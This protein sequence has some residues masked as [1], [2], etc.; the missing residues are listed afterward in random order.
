MYKLPVMMEPEGLLKLNLKSIYFYEKVLNAGLRLFLL[1]LFEIYNSLKS[2]LAL[3]KVILQSLFVIVSMVTITGCNFNSTQFENSELVKTDSVAI[4]LSQYKLENSDL[5]KRKEYLLKAY[6]F[7]TKQPNDTLKNRN[8]LKITYEAYN[9]NDT[10]F[11]KKLN[12]EAQKL[13][14]KIRDTFGIADTHWNYG[15][16]LTDIEVMDSAYYH[17]HQAYKNFLFIKKDYHSGIMLYNMA[18]I[19]GRLRD[20]TGSEISLFQAITKFKKLKKYR[21]LYQ[22]YNYLG[23]IYTEMEEFDSAIYYHNK[24]LEY[25]RQ[26]ENKDDH[27]GGSLNNI[28]L[29]YQ[30]QGNHTK[31]IDFFNTAL[32]INLKNKNIELYARLIDNIAYSKFKNADTINIKASFL[33]ALHLRDSIKNKSGVVISKIHLAEYFATQADTAT[34]LTYA[35]QAYQLSSQIIN[36]RD[37]LSILLLLSKLDKNKSENHLN[38]YIILSNKLEF[39]DRKIRNKFAKIRFETDEYITETEKLSEQKKLIIGGSITGLLFF[40]LL[41]FI[42]IQRSKNKALILESEQQK[43]NEEIYSLLLKQQSKL[44]E[45]RLKERQRIAEE[46]HDGVLSKIFGTRLGLGFLSIQGDNETLEKHT[47]F[48]EELQLIEKEIRAISHELKTEFLSANLDY[49]LIIEDLLKNKS[50]I[51]KFEYTIEYNN[52]PEWEAIDDIIKIHFYRILQEALQNIIKYATA[53]KVVLTFNSE[54]GSLYFSISDNGTGFDPKTKHK[55]IGLKNMQS[56][57]KKLQGKLTIDTAINKGTTI[58]VSCPIIT[59]Y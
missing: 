58:F 48:I 41:F 9:L 2:T 11:F 8:L 25:L 51:G 7:N 24:A 52:P 30:K 6:Y 17:Y 44:E 3:Y 32:N 55:G 18:F 14:V 34:A 50:T 27:E 40:S 22:C 13:S 54:H 29:V 47:N 36:N 39:Q 28:G 5:K 42:R 10:L 53:T 33:K 46:L 21:N 35:Q 56:R 43:A 31:A 1:D 15:N 45:E 23:L 26:V 38:N 4:L 16:Y 19:Q 57:I 37:V 59:K 12:T 20:Y 49:Q